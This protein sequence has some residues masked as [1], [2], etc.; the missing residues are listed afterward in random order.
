MELQIKEYDKEI[1]MDFATE[2]LLIKG[3]AILHIKETNYR[4]FN[5]CIRFFVNYSHFISPY[6]Q[7]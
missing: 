5:F 6:L 3:K 1:E 2:G 7:L 4:N